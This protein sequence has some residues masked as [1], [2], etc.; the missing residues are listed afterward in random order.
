MSNRDALR[1]LSRKF[2]T[3][4]ELEKIINELD[5]QPDIGAVMVS[6]S[7]LDALLER[8]LVMKFAFK[9]SS[10][11]GQI[12]DNRGPLSDFYGKILVAH[13]FRIIP[14][15]SFNELN[16]IK[17]I[18]NAFAHAKTHISFD[19]K[20]VAKELENLAIMNNLK[21]L[22]IH[23]EL[24]Q[25]LSNKQLFQWEIRFLVWMFETLIKHPGSASEALAEVWGGEKLQSSK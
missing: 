4:P 14:P 11:L 2:P 6:S 24:F 22:P 18:R 17:A 20:H 23:V 13:A 8:L 21:T 3:P 10:L 16:S 5:K 12:F 19:D 7:I 15:G 25:N 1:R 9:Y